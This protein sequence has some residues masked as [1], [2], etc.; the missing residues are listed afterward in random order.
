MSVVQG[1]R[2]SGV[3][4]SLILA[5]LFLFSLF[6]MMSP[7][8]ELD[9]EPPLFH[10]SAQN[11]ALWGETVSGTQST[12]RVESVELDANGNTYVCGYFY[13]TSSF[14]NIN[15]HSQGSYDGFV[16]KIGPAG[17]WLWAQRLG[18]SSSS[19]YCYDIDVDDGGNISIT[20]SFYGSASFGS[21]TYLSSYG[22]QDIF[23]AKLDTNGSWI[24]AVRAGS[25]SSDYG[26]GV[27]MDNNGNVYVTGHYYGTCYFGGN[28]LSHYSWDDWFVA[29]LDTNGNWVWSKRLY[30]NYY[31]YG[32]GIDVNDNGDIAVVGASSYDIYLDSIGWIYPQYRSS[33]YRHIF[34]AQLT[35]SGNFVAGKY[36]ESRTSYESW[37]QDVVIDNQGQITIVGKMYYRLYFQNQWK[38]VNSGS[39]WDCFVASYSSGLNEMAFLSIGGSST[40]YCWSV[41]IDDV[42]GELVVAG[43]FYDTAWAGGL[44]LSGHGS[45]DAFFVTLSIT[46]GSYSINSSHTFGGSSSDYAFG[47][48]I[49]NGTVVFGG[50]FHSTGYDDQSSITMSSVG[51]A[52]GWIISYGVDSD[53]DGV[54]DGV[55]AFPNDGS[56]WADSDGD[57]FGD[58]LTGFQGD[59]CPY[60]YGNSTGAGFFGCIDSDGDGWPDTIDHLPDDPTQWEDTDG[61]GFGN[62][63]NGTTPDG[64]PMMWGNSWRDQYGCLDL[65]G[66]GQ[67][68]INDRFPSQPTQWGDAD[69]D[70]LGDNWADGSWNNTRAA[71]WPGFWLAG[72]YSPDP[73]PMD[74]DNDGFEDE[75]LENSSQPW[76]DCEY[77]VGDSWRNL[78]GCPDSD[79]DGWADIEDAVPNNPSQ[80]S[81][82]DGDGYGDNSNGTEVDACPSRAGNS[83]VDRFGCPDNDGDGLSNDNDDCPTV[84]GLPTNG[85]PDRDG[86]GYVDEA[87]ESNYPVDDCPDEYGTSHEDQYGCPDS[88]GDGYSDDGDPFPADGSQWKDS[89]DDG[90]GDNPNGTD[91]DDCPDRWG[92]SSVGGLLGCEDWDGDGY[93]DSIDPFPQNGLIWSDIDGDGFADQPGT[94]LSDDC[95]SKSGN[96]TTFMLGCP[97]LDGDGIPDS[98]D[99]DIDGDGYSNTDEVRSDP[100][101]NPLDPNSVPIDTDNDGRAD[102]VA[103]SELSDSA[104][105]QDSVGQVITGAVLLLVL[106]S[107]GI[108]GVSMT[109]SSRSRKLFER[110]EGELDS[111]EGFQGLATLEEELDESLRSGSIAGSQGMLL[112][113]KIDERRAELE[114][115]LRI[116]QQAEWWAQ[117]GQQQQQHGGWYPTEGQAQWYA[118]QYEQQQGYDQQQGYGQQ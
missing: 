81:D 51:G 112:R 30:G 42:T 34:V 44:T 90:F 2:G 10:S 75:G 102:D 52:D 53:G 71:H 50:Y 22:S 18:G 8:A 20:G 25:S 78:I 79:G 59:D 21:S 49:H 97:D 72:A 109:S 108:I 68:V 15:L 11:T 29:K 84:A 55:D 37:G 98:W 12:D 77:L 116:S 26:R 91:A 39:G 24:W 45:Q 54:G 80:N 4:K 63:P 74:W 113:H 16:G 19:D 60:I 85:C 1:Y 64:C 3:L 7:Q 76:D 86:D 13:G 43:E 65:D 38:Y 58:N 118:G 41:D 61:D 28:T 70:G 111:A 73:S 100:V 23:A 82:F 89:D 114:E 92:N 48:A 31:D 87:E 9:A 36:L 96:S 56:Q 40:D 115:E 17:N 14:G 99:W 93:S 101:S 33:S 27:A 88:D 110:M 46:G 106:F 107:V 103:E 35:N 83:T 5:S 94:N 104:L 32:Y 66:D 62:N 117:M 47:S 6:S 105:L 57:G 95:I 67:S 69:G